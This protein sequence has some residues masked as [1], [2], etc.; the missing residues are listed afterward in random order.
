MK[1]LRDRIVS[2]RLTP[3][4]H[5]EL[6]AVA[7]TTV[8]DYIRRVLLE[9]VRYGSRIDGLESR[10]RAL[11]SARSLDVRWP[12]PPSATT[13]DPQRTLAEWQASGSEVA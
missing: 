5:T 7:G 4:E 11:E 1:Q 3:A 8:S 13:V 6:M 10:V 2:L 9:H 12:A